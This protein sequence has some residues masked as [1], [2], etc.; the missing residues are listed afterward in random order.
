MGRGLS[1]LQKDI[2][3]VVDAAQRPLAAGR[4][5]DALD[6]PRTPAG[7]AALSRAL[8]RL[9]VR[10]EL[11]ALIT[12]AALSGRGYVYARHDPDHPPCPDDFVQ[13][14]LHRGPR[15]PRRSS[16]TIVIEAER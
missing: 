10:K 16:K 2:L 4:F 7:R 6:L 12:Q 13:W 15:F 9:V 1:Q 8:R 14:I 5:L 3:A 11:D